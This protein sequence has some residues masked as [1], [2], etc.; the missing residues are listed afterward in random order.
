MDGPVGTEQ[1]SKKKKKKKKIREAKKTKGEKGRKKK[2]RREKK[3]GQKKR[4]NL[5]WRGPGPVSALPVP[6]DF[7]RCP[8]H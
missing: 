2:K 1:K 5:A 3:G 7:G 4:V 6:L 8:W